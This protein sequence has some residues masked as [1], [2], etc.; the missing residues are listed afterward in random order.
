LI[1]ALKGWAADVLHGIRTSATY[2]ETLQV[3]EDVSEIN[4]RRGHRE[5]GNPCKNFSAA[6]KELA[7]SAYPT[8]PED[9]MMRGAGEAFADGV[10]DL[11][12][13]IQLL[14]G[15]GKTVNGALRLVL[16]LQTVLLAVRPHKASAKT[17][18]GNRSPSPPPTHTHTWRRDVRRPGCWN[19]GK[20]GH[21]ESNCPYGK[22]A[23]NDW[24]LKCEDK[25][26]RNTR[27]MR[28][29]RRP[30]N[31]RETKRKGGQLSG[32]E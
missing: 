32:K 13:K 2:D 6:I 29:E 4:R 18:C 26:S 24:R 3:L 25:P 22:K 15:G 7:H 10:Q 20:S 21:F 28:S 27:E 17:S 11:N 31:N 8:L 23:E 9:H 14:L 5:Q 30:R 16:E 12:T 19:Y 1:I